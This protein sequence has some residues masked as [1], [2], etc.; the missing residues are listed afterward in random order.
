MQSIGS[1][2]KQALPVLACLQMVGNFLDG[3]TKSMALGRGLAF[4]WISAAFAGPAVA[5]DLTGDLIVD[6]DDLA[7]FEAAFGSESFD[8]DYRSASDLNSDGTIDGR[9]LALFMVDFPPSLA[10]HPYL[11]P[12]RFIPLDAQGEP[13]EGQFVQVGHDGSLPP[14][15]FRPG[16]HSPQER[17]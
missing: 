9:D 6:C 2:V 16:G 1:G 13:M 10:C 12:D 15:E 5:T 3:K 14:L 4:L 8:P 7:A 11:D 17:G